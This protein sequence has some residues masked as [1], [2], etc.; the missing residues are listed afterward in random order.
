MIAIAF[1]DPEAIVEILRRQRVPS[2]WVISIFDERGLRVARSRAHAENLG[3]PGAPSVVALM[4]RPEAE[5]WGRTTAIE[6]EPIYTAYS[7]VEPVHWTVATGIPVALVDHAIWRSASIIGG[8]IVLSIVAGGLVALW[9]ARGITVPMGALRHAAEALGRREPLDAPPATTIAEIRDVGDALVGAA[10][11]RLRSERERDDLLRR[12]QE[13]RAAAEG[14]NRAKDEFLAMLGH[15]LR[16]PLGA[17]A[18]ASALLEHTRAGAE[19]TGH[20]RAIISRQTAH[21][22]RLTDDLLDAARA[23]TGKI[24]LHR[25]P[26]DLADMVGSALATMETSGRLQDREMR[27]D[28]RSV[29]VDADPIRIEQIVVNLVGNALKYTANGGRITVHVGAEA[30]D[31]VLRIADD[32]IGM[33]PELA[34]RAF[35]LFAQGDRSLDRAQGGLGVGLTLVRRL[36]ELHG[37]SASADSDGP[38]RGSTFVVRLPAVPLP[39]RVG[40]LRL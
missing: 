39:S 20:A 3:K 2:D 38:S 12:E 26:V 5:G 24:V 19:T 17:I 9:I 35:D 1:V 23:I 14:A 31:A 27:R 40:P 10:A 18:N 32:G 16:N 7:R 34:G 11:E 8:G 15:E 13:A 28:L 30:G 29:G 36:A 6:G 21:L 4:A 22:A 25:R 33:S 37:G